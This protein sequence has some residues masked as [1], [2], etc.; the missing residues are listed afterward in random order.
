[1]VSLPQTSPLA[2]TLQPIPECNLIYTKIPSPLSPRSIHFQAASTP[3]AKQHTASQRDTPSTTSS[4]SMADEWWSA[5]SHRSHGTSACSAA[6]LMDTG[7]AAACAWTSPA[8]E[9]TSSIT[10]QDPRWSRNTSHQPASSDAVSSHGDPH[11]D[12][13][14]AFL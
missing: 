9:S 13:T 14:Q 3:Q 8:A 11:M 12:W 7:H 4:I 1:M 5:S 10:F 6:P 2:L